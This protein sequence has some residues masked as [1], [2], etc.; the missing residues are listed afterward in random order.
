MDAAKVTVDSLKSAIGFGLLDPYSSNS[1]AKQKRVEAGVRFEELEISI[2][3]R[4]AARCRLVHSDTASHR[5][6]V[7]HL[8]AGTGALDAYPWTGSLV[9]REIGLLVCDLGEDATREHPLVDCV[10]DSWRLISYL[11]LRNDLVDP[12]RIYC[13]ADGHLAACALCAAA[14]DDRIRGL[15]LEIPAPHREF[16][17]ESLLPTAV[18]LMAPRPLAIL[19]CRP[20]PETTESM[21]KFV[22]QAEN[23]YRA[24]GCSDR[25]WL[26]KHESLDFAQVLDR[27]LAF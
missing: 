20:G 16:S 19:D 18:A 3:S 12:R 4:P 14:I 9:E 22:D 2:E 26:G 13:T 24:A 15:V 8:Q 25:L 6:A 1:W 11:S 17:G 7:L 23:A 27:M 21:L 10:A 5:P